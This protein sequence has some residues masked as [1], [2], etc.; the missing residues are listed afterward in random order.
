MTK[1]LTDRAL[2]ERLPA[3]GVLLLES[4]HSPQFTM[5]WRT[6]PFVKIVYVLCGSGTFYL[7]GKKTS[8]S[9]GDVISV[10]PGIRNRIED[11]PAEASSLYV[12][13]IAKSV[14]RFDGDLVD[15][16]R[17]GTVRGDGHFAN[18]VSGTLR[19]MVHTQ[20]SQAADRPIAMVL[21]ALRLVQWI[22]ESR[23]G[24][25]QSQRPQVVG[26]EDSIDESVRRYIDSLPARFFEHA[27]IDQAAA[28]LGISRRSFTDAFARQTGQTWLTYVR[29][30][31][32]DHARRRLAE[33][34]LPIVSVAFECGF[35][36]LSTFYRQFKSQCGQSPARYRAHHQK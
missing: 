9:G 32:I 13:C 26:P 6:H 36:D 5:D 18:R 10:A 2:P 25:K 31:A 20:D 24:S 1:R 27:S 11:D 33:T 30:L 35:N 15:R 22:I 16:I 19:R 14:L 12:C 29:G 21:D 7:D 3:W 4:H 28:S 23:T 34:N 17:T 8:F